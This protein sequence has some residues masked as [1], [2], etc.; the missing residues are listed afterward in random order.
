MSTGKIEINIKAYISRKG[1]N[2]IKEQIEKIRIKEYLKLPNS[3]FIVFH[4]FIQLGKSENG[5]LL[6]YRNKD[7]IWLSIQPKIKNYVIFKTEESLMNYL[8]N[9]IDDKTDLTMVMRIQDNKFVEYENIPIN[10]QT[11]LHTSINI[12]Q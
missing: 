9:E 7:D 3:K 1:E 8:K 10:P 4:M 5:Y 12:S 2:Q 6:D 11:G